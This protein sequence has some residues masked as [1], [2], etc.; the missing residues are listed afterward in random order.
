MTK[1]KRDQPGDPKISQL[2]EAITTLKAE[3]K[4]RKIV[5]QESRSVKEGFPL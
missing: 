3:G 4:K 1:M 2:Q 5:L